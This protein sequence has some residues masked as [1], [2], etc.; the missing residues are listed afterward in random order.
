MKS[1]NY[2]SAKDSKEASK[3][4]SSNSAYLAGGMTLI[5]SIKQKLSNPSD[6]ID[7]QNI[8]ELKQIKIEK[9]KIIIG[10]LST[11]NQVANSD[12]IIKLTIGNI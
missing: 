11:H 12:I 5:P 1:F 4:S 6:L 3:L 8:S 2:H 7:L 10:A 9:N